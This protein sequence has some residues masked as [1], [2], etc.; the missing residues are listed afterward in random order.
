M[1]VYL[2]YKFSDYSYIQSSIEKL[3]NMPEIS[4]FYFPAVS[5]TNNTQ[6]EQFSVEKVDEKRITRWKRKAKEKI[7]DADIVCYF[8]SIKTAQ[9]N[10]RN[11]EWEYNYASKC[12]KKIIIIDINNQSDIV[13]EILSVAKTDSFFQNMF[14]YKYDEKQIQTKPISF[15]QAEK[16][17]EE[18]ST[19]QLEDKLLRNDETYIQKD[20]ND[21]YYSLLMDQYKL[22]IDTSEKLMERRQKMSSLY[23]SVCT[24][25]VAL[26]G[27]AFALKNMFALGAIFMCVGIVSIILATTWGFSLQGYDKNNEGKFAVLNA[28]EKKLPANM[29]DSEYRYNKSR[30][31]K[32]FAARERM[33]PVIFKILGGIFMACGIAV[34]VL[35]CCGIDFFMV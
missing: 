7:K 31:I 14:N 32:S 2:I 28:I 4:L 10:S 1:N 17:L 12:N 24:A 33:L 26:V 20:N 5:K 3:E 27:S 18:Q 13:N 23:T 35:Q 29:F 11:I 16:K 22:M 6:D 21:K 9:E 30:G 25:L 19:W 34:I 15:E 8:F